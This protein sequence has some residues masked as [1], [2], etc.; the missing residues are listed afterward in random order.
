VR[1]V[2]HELAQRADAGFAQWQPEAADLLAE[3]GGL[4]HADAGHTTVSASSIAWG[5]Q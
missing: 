4:S 5:K 1:A 3:R 2:E